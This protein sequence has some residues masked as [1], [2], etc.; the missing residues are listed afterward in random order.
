[1]TNT[2]LEQSLGTLA[3]GSPAPVGEFV[4]HV[5]DAR[6]W[7]SDELY[8]IF[9]FAPGEV[10][11][12]TDLIASHRHPDDRG[13]TTR[14]RPDDLQDGAAFCRR[15][16]ILDA[17]NR[18]R[19]LLTVARAT[20]S[21]DG[22]VQ[23]VRGYVV[24]LTLAN[25]A[26]AQDE[27][28]AAVAGVTVHRAAIEQAKGMLMVLLRLSGGEAFE[29]MRGYSQQHNIKLK[30]LAERLVDTLHRVE[31]P[32]TRSELDS[33]VARMGAKAS[34]GTPHREPLRT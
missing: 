5:A 27:V 11:P 20:R 18:E 22:E 34:N 30:L 7:W 19:T 21:P 25:R 9:G 13:P 8:A 1:M 6:W 26:A 2:R 28:D 29:L 16:R 17:R 15:H 4:L 24:D 10:V 23:E 14:S 12:S 33:L 31:G 32:A 3:S